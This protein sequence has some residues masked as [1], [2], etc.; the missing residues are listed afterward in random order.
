MRSSHD[1]SGD[2]DADAQDDGSPQHR[3]GDIA[4]LDDLFVQVAGCADVE[5]FV[6]NDGEAGA[7]ERED[8][9]VEERLNEGGRV[10]VTGGSLS[11]QR[12]EKVHKD[13]VGNAVSVRGAGRP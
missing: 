6:A 13:R 4:V 5:N 8:G 7:G 9:R 12:C 3:G 1:S 10:P 2:D 11:E